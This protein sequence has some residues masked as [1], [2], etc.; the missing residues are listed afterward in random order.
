MPVHRV[1]KRSV[2][3][4]GAD[5]EAKAAALEGSGEAVLQVLDHG[6]EWIIV[7][8]PAPRPANAEWETRS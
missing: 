5:L 4:S 3:D 6:R 1:K 7:T 2:A 8:A